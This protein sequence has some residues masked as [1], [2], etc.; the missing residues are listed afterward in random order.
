MKSDVYYSEATTGRIEDRV[1]ALRKILAQANPF[2][3]LKNDEYIPVKL[4]IG[5]TACAHNVSPD[6]VR[7]VIA[8]IRKRGARPFLFDTSVIYKGERQV[9]V[10]HLNLAERKGFGHSK[11]GAPFIIADGVFGND[12]REY[13]LGSPDIDKIK[14]PSFVG[15]TDS[16]VV[17]THATGHIVSKYAGAIKNIAMGMACRPTKQVQHSSLKPMIIEKACVGCGK[18]V[19]ICPV[20]AITLAVPGG[21]KSRINQAACVGCGECLCAC[22]FNAIM[23]NWEEDPHTFCRRMVDV[24]VYVLSK[25]SYTYHIMFALD[26]TKDCDCISSKDDI[27]VADNIGIL[28]STDILAVEKATVDLIAKHKKTD[29]F[30]KDR[31]IFANMLDYAAEK[32]LGSLD[33]NL[34]PCRG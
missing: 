14:V 13:S 24:A 11:V 28:A 17:L 34:I 4:T 25:F 6:L 26:I 29:F 27:M 21:K 7:L 2:A 18:C 15:M 23:L 10:D 8:D 32:K 1:I 33:Y 19:A 31:D 20:N 30:A 12:G 16:L 22:T 9:A 3:P 5:D